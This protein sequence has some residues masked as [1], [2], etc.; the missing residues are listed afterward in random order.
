MVIVV[1]LMVFSKKYNGRSSNRNKTQNL[2][3]TMGLD[4]IS[5]EVTSC[6]LLCAVCLFIEFFLIPFF[7]NQNATNSLPSKS[8]HYTHLP[9]SCSLKF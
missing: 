9:S 8:R 5:L 1:A 6:S 3:P 4:F 2:L 7:L